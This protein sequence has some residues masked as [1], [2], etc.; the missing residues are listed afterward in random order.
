M[1]PLGALLGSVG[2]MILTLA[3]MLG[4]PV[5][6]V[7]LQARALWRWHG[8]WRLAA[9]PPLFLMGAAVAYMARLLEEG[10]NLAPVVVI[11]LIP[12]ALVW[13]MVAGA[14]RKRGLR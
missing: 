13:L 11:F 12:V 2:T 14:L 4:G 5:L 9:L 6:Y 1:G 10:S 8:A 7:V 3:L